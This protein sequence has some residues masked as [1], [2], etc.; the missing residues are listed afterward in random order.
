MEK[1][2]K[3]VAKY[4]RKSYINICIVIFSMADYLHFGRHTPEMEDGMAAIPAFF[5]A[6]TLV[7][8]L[9]LV[10]VFTFLWLL[11]FRERLG[12]PW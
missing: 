7:I 6:H 4:N 5:H 8:I 12:M 9:V 10:A 11:R 3:P 1:N 2:E